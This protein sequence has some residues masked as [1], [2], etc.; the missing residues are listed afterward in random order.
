MSVPCSTHPGLKRLRDKL[1]VVVPLNFL[2]IH[3]CYFIFTSLITSA[4]FYAGSSSS[5]HVSFTDALF[6]CISAITGA[7]LN[8]VSRI[9]QDLVHARL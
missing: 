5:G 9:R 7:G 4:I 8:T 2:T 3:Y 1:E 6:L